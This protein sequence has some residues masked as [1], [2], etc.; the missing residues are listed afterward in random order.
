[1]QKKLGVPRVSRGSFSEAREVFDPEL[2]KPIIGELAKERGR[3][4]FPVSTSVASTSWLGERQ[5]LPYL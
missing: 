2:L 1:M 5:A 4:H 3:N